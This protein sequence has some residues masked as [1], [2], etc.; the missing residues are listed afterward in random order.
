MSLGAVDHGTGRG[1]AK[2]VLPS[3]PVDPA[4]AGTELAGGETGVGLV[5]PLAE[6]SLVFK[7][8]IGGMPGLLLTIGTKEAMGCEKERASQE[9]RADK[10]LSSGDAHA[11]NTPLQRSEPLASLILAD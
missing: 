4:P 5:D 6:I 2:S 3:R 9:K 8:A 10:K 1:A 7:A 11:W